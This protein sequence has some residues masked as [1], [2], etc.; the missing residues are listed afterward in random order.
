MDLYDT[1]FQ[2]YFTYAGGLTWSLRNDWTHWKR[3]LRCGNIGR[4]HCK[5]NN[6]VTVD[7]DLV[8]KNHRRDFLNSTLPAL[9][10]D[11]R[12][13]NVSL[14]KVVV[15]GEL[16]RWMRSRQQALASTGS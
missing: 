2:R 10:S 3:L 15:R 1:E 11:P 7:L 13:S 8:Q 4:K 5:N 9:L 16:P 12:Y 14:L 6:T